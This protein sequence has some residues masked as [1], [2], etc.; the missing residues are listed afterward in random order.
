MQPPECLSRFV[1]FDFK[2]FASEEF[3]EVA[4][5]IITGQAGNLCDSPDEVDRLESKAKQVPWTEFPFM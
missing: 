2:P 1:T 3:P 4:Q 5:K